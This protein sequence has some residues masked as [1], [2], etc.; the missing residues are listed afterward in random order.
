MTK[1][2]CRLMAVIT[3]S[4]SLITVQ[5]QPLKKE[6][7]PYKILTSGR[8][9]TIKSSKTIQ[10]VMIWTTDGHRV[11]EQKAIN[12]TTVKVDIPVSRNTFYLMI[13]MPGGKVYTE[14]IGIQ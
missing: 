4:V 11:V 5:A 3:L 7:K 12:E 2:L 14:R 1:S 9:L 8:Q 10:N 13:E 6:N